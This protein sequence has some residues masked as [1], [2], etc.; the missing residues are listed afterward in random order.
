MV[1]FY[2]C[3]SLKQSSTNFIFTFL[4]VSCEKISLPRRFRHGILGTENAFDTQV[5]TIS[6]SKKEIYA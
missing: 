3:K 6:I 4:R 2:L 5:E 1:L